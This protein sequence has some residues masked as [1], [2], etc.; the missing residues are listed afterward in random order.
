M[1]ART[2]SP[3]L[4]RFIVFSPL[5]RS[6]EDRLIEKCGLLYSLRE[7]E[8]LRDVAR[9]IDSSVGLYYEALAENDYSDPQRFAI[10]KIPDR[11]AA[12]PLLTIAQSLRAI[13]DLATAR[14][15]CAEGARVAQRVTDPLTSY[16]CH[17]EN[18]IIQSIDGDHVGALGTLQLG[19]PLI[20][21]LNR[22]RPTLWSDF[23]NSCAVEL[24]EIG[25][26]EKARQ[27]SDIALASPFAAAYPEWQQTAAEIEARGW[28]GPSSLLVAVEKVVPN[29]VIRLDAVRESCR[30]VSPSIGTAAS[31]LQWKNVMGKSQKTKDE[32][33][34]G[35]SSW[36]SARS[37]TR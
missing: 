9:R 14:K 17:R 21:S 29:N 23:M 24:M 8:A 3:S 32:I 5:I 20:R 18:A 30:A 6:V 33:K 7:F 12:R 11:Y 22:S 25:E 10:Q 15:L 16:L 34:E 26:I 27:T 37:S 1:N 4:K 31:V 36:A 28:R 13:G 35:S 2:N 19:F